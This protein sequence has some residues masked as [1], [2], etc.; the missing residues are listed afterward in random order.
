MSNNSNNTDSWYNPIL[1]FGVH[2]LVGSAI[3]CIIAA[4]ALGLSFLVLYLETLGV[5][6][7]TLSV[8]TFLEH[9]LLMVD[10]ALFVV[11]ILITAYKAFK[12][13]LK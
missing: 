11:Y 12:E 10:A 3:F 13:M 9:A 7:F 8:L 1:H 5:P 2:T 6:A 4:P